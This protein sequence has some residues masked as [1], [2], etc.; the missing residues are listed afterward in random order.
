MKNL[1]SMLYLVALSLFTT[2]A[3]SQSDL[4]FT[5][6]ISGALPGGLPKA[7]EIYVVNDVADLSDYGIA[8][9]NNG[10]PSGGV[11]LFNFPAVSA[12]AGT[13]LYI[14]SEVDGFT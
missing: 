7:L 8:N 11:P 3:F 5:G 14:A 1:F 2:S 12:T 10:N 9:A 6:V 4:V 13:Y